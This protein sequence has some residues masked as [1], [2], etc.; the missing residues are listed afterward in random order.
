MCLLLFLPR[1]II[2]LISFEAIINHKDINIPNRFNSSIFSFSFLTL[3]LFWPNWIFFTLS[4]LS[5]FT[6]INKPSRILE[7]KEFWAK[8]KISIEDKHYNNTDKHSSFNWFFIK[9]TVR[10]FL[11][12]FNRA[13]T[14]LAK[15]FPIYK[16]VKSKLSAV[17]DSI[18][19]SNLSNF[20]GSLTLKIDLL[21][22]SFWTEL[23][24][25]G[26]TPLLKN[27]VFFLDLGLLKLFRLSCR[28][29]NDLLD[30]MSLV[31]FFLKVREGL[32]S[33]DLTKLG[34]SVCPV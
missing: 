22:L 33:P 1:H 18:I 11:Q 16:P 19:R 21:N 3:M 25:R 24:E 15:S 8:F 23:G 13:N 30:K 4:N 26:S 12:S 9:R 7:E 2:K 6:N 28:L 10:T 32:R 20:Y 5:L 31:L 34:V 29:I 17:S 27:S 14:S